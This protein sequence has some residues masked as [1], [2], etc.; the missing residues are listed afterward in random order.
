MF[1]EAA[2]EL[3]PPIICPGLDRSNPLL[4]PLFG[5]WA[6]LP[7]LLF[8]AGSTEVL[9]DDSVRSQDRASQ[10][11]V[12]AEIEVWWR[13]A[14]CVPGL[15]LAAGIEGRDAQHRGD[16]ITTRAVRTGVHADRNARDV[17]RSDRTRGIWQAP[18]AP[19]FSPRR[20]RRRRGSRCGRGQRRASS[21]RGSRPQPLNRS[22]DAVTHEGPAVVH[23][24]HHAAP[25][26]RFV[27]FTLVPKRQCRVRH[28]QG[29]GVEEL[30][31]GRRPLVELAAVPGHR[32]FLDAGAGGAE[33]QQ[34]APARR[35]RGS[36]GGGRAAYGCGRSGCGSGS[37]G[38]GPVVVDRVG[39]RRG[40]ALFAAR[41]LPKPPRPAHPAATRIS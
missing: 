5:N 38:S 11:R 3:L 2:F 8:H 22:A 17:S 20:R 35:A 36:R 15:Q 29:V 41:S 31:A 19:E 12:H 6:G 13:P 39:N 10:A 4:S 21:C 7:P 23:T 33:R 24:N 26:P 25:V 30:A 27:T 18:A 28:G 34:P 16:F 32:P 9:L 37:W 14:A 40:C 1:S